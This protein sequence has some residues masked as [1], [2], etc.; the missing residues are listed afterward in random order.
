MTIIDPRFLILKNRLGILLAVT[1]NGDGR[2]AWSM[3]GYT[4]P[5]AGGS[6]ELRWSTDPNGLDDLDSFSSTTFAYNATSGFAVINT[7]DP[8]Y[9][10]LVAKNAGGVVIARSNVFGIVSASGYWINLNAT[11][12]GDGT[13][14][15][16]WNSYP[17][18]P[19]PGSDYW[20]IQ[21]ATD[22]TTFNA[23][24]TVVAAAGT[25]THTVNNPSQSNTYR[26]LAFE[27]AGDTVIYTSEEFGPLVVTGDTQATAYNSALN[28]AGRM[29]SAGESAANQEA[30]SNLRLAGLGSPNI[31]VVLTGWAVAE[32]N[33]LKCFSLTS[34][35]EF[36]TNTHAVGGLT[37]GSDGYFGS[38]LTPSVD[39]WAGFACYIKSTSAGGADIEMGSNQTGGNS[40]LLSINFTGTY[41][42]DYGNG[43]TARVTAASGQT[44][45]GLYSMQKLSATTQRFQRFTSGGTTT[46]SSASYTSST[47]KSNR[48]VFFGAFNDSVS[49]AAFFTEKEFACFVY[50]KTTLST[51][52]WDDLNDIIIAW[53]LD[54]GWIT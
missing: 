21:L 29:P 27:D 10:R 54:L 42:L 1:N 17:N 19:D 45:P 15:L 39:G 36:G 28:M 46:I 6:L 5:D 14:S 3:T 51:T 48:E 8:N 30:F 20:E 11:N 35:S 34:C 38:G 41:F 26:L 31:E 16:T 43:T 23:V 40:Q 49:G 7:A 9:Y 25:Y 24:D 52:E 44:L 33:R 32:V 18:F 22:G 2:V 12:N 13:A 50:T 37:M 53:L 4:H 47:A